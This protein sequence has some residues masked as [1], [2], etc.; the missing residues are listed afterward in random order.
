MNERKTEDLVEKRLR[1]NDYYSPGSGIVVEKQK[2]DTTRIQKLLEN[3][4]KRGNGIGKPEFIIHSDRHPSFLVV[5]ECKAN[6]VKHVSNTLDKYNDFAVDGALLYASFLAKDYDVLAIGVSG[7]SEADIRISAY[8]HLKGSPKATAYPE[9]KEIVPFADYYHA[10]IHSDVKFRQDYQTLLEYSRK[11]NHELQARKVTEAERGFL[12]SGI[13][14]ALQNK[15]F[16]QSY[17]LQSTAKQ[18][19]KSLLET[20]ISGVRDRPISCKKGEMS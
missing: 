20:M 11:L 18:L 17:Q 19:A 10:F 8:F 12:I 9:A 6:P 15:A 2:S 16:N 3:A 5:I 7:Q 4:S 1:E 13:L 14:I